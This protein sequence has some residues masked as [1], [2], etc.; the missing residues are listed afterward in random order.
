MKRLLQATHRIPEARG[1]FQILARYKC[2]LFHPN[3]RSVKIK[4]NERKI[5]NIF[6]LIS[7]WLGARKNRLIELFSFFLISFNI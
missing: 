1:Y 4:K 3:H 5:V 2:T 7:Y 6:F